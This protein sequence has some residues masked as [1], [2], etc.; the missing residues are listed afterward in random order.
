M[1]SNTEYHIPVLLDKA[2]EFLLNDKLSKKII[3]DGTLGGGG[4]SRKICES[5]G[6][7]D[8]LISIDKD[9]NAIDHAK[10]ISR[11][12]SC[13]IFLANNNFAEIKEIIAK[14]GFEKISG[15]VL[16][17]GLST[18]QLDEEDGFSYMKNSNLDMRADKGAELKAYD[19]VNSYSKDAL[20]GVFEEFGEIGNAVRLSDI[21][22]RTRKKG[23]LE[24]TFD[25]VNTVDTE[26]KINAKDRISFL[27]KIFQSIRIEVNGEMDDLKKVLTDS[28]DSLE[29]GGRLVVVSYHS[30]E[31]RIVKNF[32]K[33][34]SAKYKQ[35]ENPFYTEDNVQTFKIITKKAITPDKVEIISNSRSRSAKLRAAER[36]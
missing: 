12:C 3:A 19:V 4:Y 17:L 5:L 22:V 21:I 35:G 27:S 25:L 34:S 7:D 11:S 28:T 1:S 30:L 16:D 23:K 14:L 32:L 8:T 20:T 26:Y 33:D 10:E 9:I 31:D 2:I 24:T 13:R 36:I 15:L 6:K 18:Y 29:S